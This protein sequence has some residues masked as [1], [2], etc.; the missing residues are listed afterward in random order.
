M[1]RRSCFW[2]PV[3]NSA[4]DRALGALLHEMARGFPP[5]ADGT[6]DAGR[7]ADPRS[8]S[9][10]A[11]GCFDAAA[12]RVALCALQGRSP[13]AGVGQSCHPFWKV[14]VCRGL[15]LRRR[16]RKSHNFLPPRRRCSKV[17]EGYAPRN[18][19]GR[20]ST[21]GRC[22]RRIRIRRTSFASLIKSS[23][24]SVAAVAVVA[25]VW[26]EQQLQELQFYEQ[27]QKKWQQQQQ[28]LRQEE[29]ELQEQLSRAGATLS[30]AR[31]TRLRAG[32]AR[33]RAGAARLSRSSKVTSRSS[34]V[35][36]RS[37]S[38]SCGVEAAASRSA[39]AR[40]VARAVL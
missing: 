27:E 6:C 22:S 13:S 16:S 20:N 1:L 8:A 12:G 11:A 35:T 2:E 29:Q 36:S 14:N 5:Y 4:S 28:R 38:S 19:T 9:S 10:R 39:G 25:A 15:D 7:S 30:R 23:S 31:A 26:E 18:G 37:R 40:A 21:C 17:L 3:C 34:K 32:A 33:L 24:R